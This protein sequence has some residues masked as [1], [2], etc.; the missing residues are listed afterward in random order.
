MFLIS[1]LHQTHIIDS[2]TYY[3]LYKTIS[4]YLWRLLQMK[5]P[6]TT[7]IMRI[8]SRTSGTMM[9]ILPVRHTTRKS[10]K[11]KP[12]LSLFP[13]VSM[14]VE[15]EIIRYSITAKLNKHY[16]SCTDIELIFN[17]KPRCIFRCVV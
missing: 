12:L 3:I 4:Q 17:T 9:A 5:T 14:Q 11:Q 1:L 7:V 15:H 6:A 13:Q 2:P 8:T 10:Q 16:R